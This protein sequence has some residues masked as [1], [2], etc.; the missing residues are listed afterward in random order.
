MRTLAAA[1]AATVRHNPNRVAIRD[2]ERSHSW[3]EFGD[4]VARGARMLAD[5]GVA[6]GER[7]AI[8]ARNGF[9]YE[10]LKWAGYWSGAVPVPI[11][12]RLAAPEMRR[13]CGK[14][15]AAASD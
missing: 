1:L 2:R 11:N 9:R 10:E 4:R 12:W 8:L 14:P 7:F 13:M 5:L 6:P 3:A 15:G